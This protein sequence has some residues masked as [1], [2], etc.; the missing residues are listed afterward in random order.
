MTMK[1]AAKDDHDDEVGGTLLENQGYFILGSPIG[2]GWA[3]L[4]FYWA[5]TIASYFIMLYLSI[6]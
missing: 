4:V 6:M 1:V 3:A 2:L 5:L